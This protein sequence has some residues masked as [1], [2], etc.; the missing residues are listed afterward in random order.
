M[1]SCTPLLVLLMSVVSSLRKSMGVKDGADWERRW[2]VVIAVAMDV[3][4]MVMVVLAFVVGVVDERCC[5]NVHRT[6]SSSHPLVLLPVV[7]RAVLPFVVI[8]TTVA[9]VADGLGFM[10]LFVLA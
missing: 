1:T 10:L 7:Y 8:A 6:L 3:S 9:G 5:F 2:G 4:S